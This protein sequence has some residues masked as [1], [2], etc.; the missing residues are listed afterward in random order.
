VFAVVTN[1]TASKLKVA[2][3]ARELYTGP[4]V[5]RVVRVVDEARSRGI[6]A[7]LYIISARYGLV[8]ENDI[9][10]PYDETLSGKRPE[11]IKAWARRTGLHAAFQKIADVA[12][13]IL[14]VSKPYY[15]A[16]EDVA[17]QSDIYVLAPYKACGKW[18][19]TGNFNKHLVLRK[20]LFSLW[21]KRG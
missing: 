12:T 17:C 8:H 6:P 13:V 18:I 3:P 20:L 14:V 1:C 9:I 21:S 11:E 10:E 16:V 4:S 2:G 5:Q 7:T 15:I 19:K